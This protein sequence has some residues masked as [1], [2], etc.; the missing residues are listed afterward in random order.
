MNYHV[1]LFAGKGKGK[2]KVVAV[3]AW[4][5]PEDSRRLRLS[6]VKTGGT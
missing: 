4:T 3:H 6:D 2:G 5:D 1:I